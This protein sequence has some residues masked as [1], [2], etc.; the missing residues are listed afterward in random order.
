MSEKPYKPDAQSEPESLPDAMFR[1]VGTTPGSLDSPE[2]A[3]GAAV[4]DS[5]QTTPHVKGHHP[6]T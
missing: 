2:A 1:N 6:K 5:E 4:P 3:V